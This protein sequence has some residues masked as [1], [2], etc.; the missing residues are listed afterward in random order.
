MWN[1]GGSGNMG[2]Y[3]LHLHVHVNESIAILA[4]WHRMYS[5][6]HACMHC[7]L[8]L[9]PL[10]DCVPWFVPV[11]N[12]HTCIHHI[13]WKMWRFCFQVVHQNGRQRIVGRQ[14]HI[15]ISS[16]H[17]DSCSCTG[18]CNSGWFVLPFCDTVTNETISFWQHL[19]WV[20]VVWS[21]SDFYTLDPMKNEFAPMQ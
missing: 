20:W 1:A 16:G 2:V 4:L 17:C 19:Y 14:T 18:T 9:W 8:P 21:G 10:S 11:L 6:M 3:T 5:Y 15:W 13:G 7:V 12:A